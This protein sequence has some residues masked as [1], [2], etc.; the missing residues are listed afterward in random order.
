MRFLATSDL[1][2]VSG[3]MP[4][5]RLDNYYETQ[6]E[7]LE[8]VFKYAYDNGCAILQ[9]GDFFDSPR[10]WYLLEDILKLFNKYPVDFFNVFGQHDTYMY[11]VESRGS[12]NLG[13][14]HGAGKIK[15]L[16]H[17]G[18]TFEK[19]SIGIY[20][21]SWGEEIPEPFGIEDFTI[22]VIHAG[23]GTNSLFP[24]HEYSDAKRFLK[25][26][27]FDLILCGDIHQSFFIQADGKIIVN[28]G[29]MLRKE[30]TNYNLTHKPH[31]YVFDTG[32]G[33]P[34]KFKRVE[35]P[36]EPAKAILTRGH[37]DDKKEQKE[38]LKAFTEEIEK[39]YPKI[40][41]SRPQE[42]EN[43][44]ERLNLFIKENNIPEIITKILDEYIGEEP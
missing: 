39:A 38:I 26:H 21:A 29:P 6:F 16:N 17:I 36:H 34:F 15:L 9:A 22:L 10:N 25:K 14:M 18:H 30:A 13:I 8:F 44:L 7:K 1:H 12:T 35:I 37:L 19:G 31:F 5:G 3:K 23:I 40:K 20:G 28:T 42:G 4:V 27:D 11:S 2:M 43:F 33:D 32:S 24:G 41:S